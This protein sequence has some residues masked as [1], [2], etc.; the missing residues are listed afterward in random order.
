VAKDDPKPALIVLDSNVFIRDYWLRSPSFVLL[1]HF[2]ATSGA[3]LVVPKI[4]LEEVINHHREDLEKLK[5]NVRSTIRDSARLL[6]NPKGHDWDGAI[7]KREKEDPYEDFL[8]SELARLKVA[9]PEYKEVPH[10]E[11]VQRDLKRRRPFQQSGKGYRDTLLWETV[12]RHCLRKDQLS[13]L[14]TENI[15]DFYGDDQEL[16]HDLRMDVWGRAKGSAGLKLVRDLPSFTD[17]YIVPFLTARKDF[18]LLIQ[19]GKVSGL[20]L[21]KLTEEKLDILVEALH[22]DADVM[23][24]D[25]GV[26]DPEVDVIED[27]GDFTVEQASEISKGVLLVVYEFNGS[28]AFTYFLPRDEYYSMS[29]EQQSEVAILDATWNEYV[30]RVE[31]TKE[32]QFRCRLTFNS[33]SNKVESFE[34]ESLVRVEDAVEM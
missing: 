1:K 10:A 6:R 16:H 29:E 18:A 3:D 26:Y 15:R 30:M 33:K 32:I 28:V 7:Y 4:V 27:V 11:I 21:G 9:I 17:V 14:V 24:Y 2:L 12:I 23:I 13:V 8:S 5:S 31:S 25:S 34:V 22:E 19:G 20:N